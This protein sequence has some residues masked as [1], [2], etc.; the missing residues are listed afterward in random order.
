MS[1]WSR[2]IWINSAGPAGLAAVL[3]LVPLRGLAEEGTDSWLPALGEQ[4]K[5]DDPLVRRGQQT[6]NAAGCVYCHGPNGAGGVAN[7]N[8]EGGSVPAL[9]NLSADGYSRADVKF[10]ILK[11]SRD[12][13]KEKPGG[14][15]PPLSMP[16]WKGVLSDDDLNAVVVFLESLQPKGGKSE[17]APSPRKTEAAASGGRRL[18][19]DRMR[20]VACHVTEL[21]GRRLGGMLGPNLSR[22]A[23]RLGPAE[24]ARIVAEPP[25]DVMP[26]HFAE[27][28]SKA[29][30]GS[31]V[32]FLQTLRGG[33]PQPPA[34]VSRVERGKWLFKRKG[35]F[36]CHGEEGR[37][38]V[39][40]YNYVKDA[41]PALNT[42]A[43]RLMLF[44]P[45]DA[46]AIVEKL[47]KGE[48]LEK[49]ADD[50]PISRYNVFLAQYKAVR[51]LIRN[52]N[53]AGKKAPDGP[54]PPMS[55]PSW[56]HALS[57]GDVDSLIAY[58]ITLEPQDRP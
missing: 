12:V 31:L 44:D 34:G 45:Q 37:G 4:V 43:E 5:T 9:T 10:R 41:V 16:A 39:H 50:P 8:A 56:E 22:I 29:E 28:M 26:K 18:F 2:R 25:G 1:S 21:D 19:Y 53:R 11:G 51:E 49:L 3:C 32:D 58:L 6:F 42:L 33:E 14:L 27:N 47:D 40:N 35:C 55:M 7:S 24:L 20:C 23:E 46:R 17:A 38:G 54:Q 57:P 48:D 36:L 30:L 52:G 13:A 15:T